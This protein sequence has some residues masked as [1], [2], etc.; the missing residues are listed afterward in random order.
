M[1]IR[2]NQLTNFKGEP[3]ATTPQVEAKITELSSS[4]AAEIKKVDDKV[5]E[6]KTEVTDGLL[7]EETGNLNAKYNPI[8]VLS[9]ENK[10]GLPAVELGEGEEKVEYF[11]DN[12]YSKIQFI[13]DCKVTYRNDGQ[14]V[15]RIGENLNSSNFNT[16][17]VDGQTTGVAGDI[18][19]PEGTSGTLSDG[20]NVNAITSGNYVVTTVTDDA[21]IHFENNE[22]TYFLM[23]VSDNNTAKTY[24]FGPITGNGTY[25]AKLTDAEGET[26][27]GVSLTVSN[28]GE[29][30]KSNEGAT[31]YCGSIKFTIAA[32][33]IADGDASKISVTSVTHKNGEEGDFAYTCAANNRYFYTDTT[34]KPTITADSAKVT[35][36]KSSTKIVSGIKYVTAGTAKYDVS[37][38]DIA[39]PVCIPS[40][41][42]FDNSGWAEDKTVSAAYNATS[43]TATGNLIKGSHSKDTAT[44]K[45]SVTVKNINGNATASIDLAESLLVDTTTASDTATVANFNIETT[46]NYQRLNDDLTTFD[47]TKAIGATDLMLKDGYLVYPSGNWSEYNADLAATGLKAVDGTAATAN[48]NYSNSEGT[49]YWYRKFYEAG[50]KNGAT[51]SFTTAANF[52]ETSFGTAMIVEIGVLNSDGT[53]KKWFDASKKSTE[54]SIGIRT[55]SNAGNDKTPTLVVNWGAEGAASY[56]VI[57]KLGL[58]E[59]SAVKV[60]TLSVTF[61]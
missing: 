9:T 6:I 34:T 47:N 58:P 57:I 14:I 54:S 55:D 48:P 40:N 25:D 41:V 27:S 50:D 17:P 49:R 42:I 16:D 31:G 61:A 1:A 53:V 22:N 59:A 43:A 37:F 4:V 51:L 19:A 56:G 35:I 44:N 21:L 60:D 7:D 39:N 13:G 10:T 52:S 26:V 12:D 23:N 2:A 20:S 29:E 5:Q 24:Y 32:S 11:P 33:A 8:K 30:T 18:T 28:F 38:S 3:Y 15:I 46:E 36:T 45:V